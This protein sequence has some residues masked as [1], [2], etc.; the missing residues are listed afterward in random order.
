MF[1]NRY[2]TNQ[3]MK[4]ILLLFLCLICLGSTARIQAQGFALRTNFL[5]WI[6]GNMNLDVSMRLSNSLTFHLPVE[7]HPAFAKVPVPVGIIDVLNEGGA[8]HEEVFFR[9][10][11]PRIN[12]HYMI[13][14]GLRY[15]MHGPYNR[16]VFFGAQA[17][18]KLYEYG[19]SSVDY[20]VSKGYALG[21]GLSAGYNWDLSPRMNLEVEVGTGLLWHS[22]NR[23]FES[24]QVNTKRLYARRW[25]VSRLG[26]SLTYL[27]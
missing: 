21:A 1:M 9:L 26:L 13:Q 4:R 8:F 3:N 25:G 6:Q 20:R 14:P 27:L 17:I 22:Y 18:G 24:N 16:G 2:F 12:E 11:A 10:E 15:W 19:D 5:A 7:V 23:Y